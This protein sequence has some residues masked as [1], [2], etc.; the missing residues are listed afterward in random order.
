MRKKFQGEW[1][2]GETTKYNPVTGFYTIEYQDGDHE[3]F[4]DTDTEMHKK[5]VQ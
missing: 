4:D 1:Y 5:E 2:E 3:E